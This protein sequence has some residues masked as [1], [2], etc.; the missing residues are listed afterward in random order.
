[1]AVMER[2]TGIT[3]VPLLEDDNLAGLAAI[4]LLNAFAPQLRRS[5]DPPLRLLAPRIGE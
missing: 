1:M 3:H 5:G 2:L 4:V